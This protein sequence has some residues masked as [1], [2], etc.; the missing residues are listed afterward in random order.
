MV[1]KRR[2]VWAACAGGLASF[3]P[4]VW[5]SAQAQEW[6]TKPIKIIEPFPA[7]VARDARTRVIA[8][9]LEYWDSRSML[10]IGREPLVA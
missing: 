9:K 10:K 3:V 5:Q 8:E 1:T 6:P 2:F 7:G 4:G